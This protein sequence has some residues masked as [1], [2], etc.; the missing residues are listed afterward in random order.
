[1]YMHV[2]HYVFLI[3]QLLQSDICVHTIGGNV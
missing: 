3:A 1:M 2:Q